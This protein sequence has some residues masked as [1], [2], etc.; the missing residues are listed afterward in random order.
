MIEI[1]VDKQVQDLTVGVVQADG[2]RIEAASAGLRAYCGEMTDRVLGAD[3]AGGDRRREAIR[4]LL[5]AGGF[6]PAGRNKPAQEYLLRTV[7]QDRQLPSILNVVDLLNAVSLASGLPISMLSGSQLGPRALIRYG[8]HGEHY[9]F[10][11]SGQELELCGLLCVCSQSAGGSIPLAT[12]VKDSMVGKVSEADAAILSFLYA[13]RHEI[14]ASELV[15]WTQE[16][17]QGLVRW[18]GASS[19]QSGILP[20]ASLG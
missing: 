6:K 19:Y 3:S 2:V 16:L 15:H 20:P 11:R 9:V 17:G 1:A 8:C 12:P 7:R 10:N 5:R 4:L 14:T 18:C 13:S